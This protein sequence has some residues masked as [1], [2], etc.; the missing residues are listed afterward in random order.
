MEESTAVGV[1]HAE[2]V[3]VVS[4]VFVGVAGGHLSVVVDVVVVVLFDGFGMSTGADVD[5]CTSAVFAVIV[6]ITAAAVVM[7]V[8]V[9]CTLV[10]DPHVPFPGLLLPALAWGCV[11]C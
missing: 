1:R 9:C 2:D 3:S 7:G 8:V 11:C 5:C 10:A 6:G 4:L